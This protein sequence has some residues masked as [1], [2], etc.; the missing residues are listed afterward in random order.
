MGVLQQRSGRVWEGGVISFLTAWTLSEKLFAFINRGLNKKWRGV[1]GVADYIKEASGVM[2]MLGYKIRKIISACNL[3]CQV[4]AFYEILQ[5]LKTSGKFCSLSICVSALWRVLKW[6]SSSRL[7]RCHRLFKP[8]R[9]SIVLNISTADGF[10]EWAE[11]E[12]RGV[13]CWT[14]VTFWGWIVHHSSWSK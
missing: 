12:V 9:N 10:T 1:R 13:R 5:P 2:F 8:N 4:K 11:L 3:T 7:R 6:I 14:R